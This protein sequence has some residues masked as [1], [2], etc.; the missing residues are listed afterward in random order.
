MPS[1][2]RLSI[3]EDEYLEVLQDVSIFKEGE[4]I[5]WKDG[6]YIIRETVDSSN[7]VLLLQE[8]TKFLN[9]N[10]DKENLF[11]EVHNRKYKI[12]KGMRVLDI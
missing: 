9:E 11:K 12:V 4:R 10:W 3:T 8:P 1:F 5:Y 6:C 2:K 7:W